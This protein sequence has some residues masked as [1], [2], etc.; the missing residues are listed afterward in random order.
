MVA[1]FK[2]ITINILVNGVNDYALKKFHTQ[3]LQVTAFSQFMILAGP[4]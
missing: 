3:S 1:T 2:Q 4:P